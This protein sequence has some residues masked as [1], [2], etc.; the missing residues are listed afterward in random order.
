MR[1]RDLLLLA[2]S[3]LVLAACGGG[4]S[5]PRDSFYRLTIDDPGRRY[6]MPVLDGTV[7][8]TRFEAD[9]L[10]SERAVIYQESGPALRQYSYHYWVDSPT[11]LLQEAVVNALR[12][13][14]A[15]RRVVTPGARVRSDYQVTGKLNQLQH[16]IREGGAEVVIALDINVTR[17]ADGR[18]VLHKRYIERAPVLGE[19]VPAA[20]E[21]F[22]TAL[23]G[24]AARLLDDLAEANGV[25]ST[26]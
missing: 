4:G 19:G 8:V 11:L 22:Q 3:G 20:V 23:T 6:G 17:T 12:Q 15:A 13:S 14:R 26:G 5:V 10:T 21:E 1:R 16:T 7:E 9:G 2:G 24:V 25:E 18:L